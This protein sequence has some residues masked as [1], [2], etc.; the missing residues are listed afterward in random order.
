MQ[1]FFIICLL[2]NIGE[3]NACAGNIILNLGQK[4]AVFSI[5]FITKFL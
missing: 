3:N 4:C 2:S 1:N 5:V